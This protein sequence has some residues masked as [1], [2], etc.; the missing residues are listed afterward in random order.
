MPRFFLKR[1][2]FPTLAVYAIKFH[3]LRRQ[4]M[5]ESHNVMARLHSYCCRGRATMLCFCIVVLRSVVRNAFVG[6]L[7]RQNRLNVFR[8]LHNLTDFVQPKLGCPRHVFMKDPIQNFT[9]MSSWGHADTGDRR[10][11]RLKVM[12]KA[13]DVLSDCAGA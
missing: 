10:V 7:C 9:E 12:T 1:R 11:D 4:A 2:N 13:M 6:V 5:Y 3:S 8:Y